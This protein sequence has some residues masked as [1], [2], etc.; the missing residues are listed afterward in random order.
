MRKKAL[1][2]WVIIAGLL[3][4]LAAQDK[5]QLEK[6]RQAIQQELKDIQQMYNKVK[7]QTKQTLGQ[8][9]VLN[10]KIAL[11]EQYL[12]NINKEIRNIDDDIY[13]SNLEIYRLQKQLDTLK[14]QYA[15]SVVYA[16]KNKSNY[17]YLNFIFSANSFN[18]A[19]KRVAYLK[20]YRAYREKQV[21]TILETKDLIAKRKEQQL[22]RKDQKNSALTNQTKQVQELEV[23]KKEKA[24]VVNQLKSKEKDLST[25]IAAKKKRD[26]ELNNAILAIVRRE[27]ESAKAKAKAEA[28]AKRKADEIAKANNPTTVIKPDNTGK[29][30][31]GGTTTTAVTTK[32]NEVAK[33]PESYLDLNSKD[34][35]LNS[36]FA[37][38]RAKLP[39]PVDNGIVALRFGNNKIENT[40]LTFDNPG[41][42][43]ATPS[44]GVAVKAVFDGEV[45]AVYSLG[46]GSA[47]TIR[48]G[49]YFTTYSNLSGVTV[50]KGATVKTGQT[51]G[52]AGRDDE[53]NGGQIDFILMIETKNVDPLPWL[54]R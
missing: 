46:D 7:G 15:R 52:K 11:Q 40:L 37:A 35:A 2:F 54:R 38:N 18:D 27:I 16:Y 32:R 9:N 34:V 50:S 3:Q 13:L 28:E 8:L 5:A 21:T 36:S 29:P 22:V 10:R 4:G 12:S 23:Q 17:D 42:T 19:I 41:L 44:P 24:T 43:I 47:V 14:I 33:K 26:K 45:S 53:G 30:V 49:K 1:L 20:S 31:D 51:I 39:W 25:Q 6:E 48:H